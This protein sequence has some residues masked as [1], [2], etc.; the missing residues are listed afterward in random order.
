MEKVHYLALQKNRE[1]DWKNLQAANKQAEALDKAHYQAIKMNSDMIAKN[2]KQTQ[3]LIN[4]AF[5][6]KQSANSASNGVAE[7]KALEVLNRQYDKVLSNLNAAKNSGKQLSDSELSGINRRIEA[8][9]NLGSRQ[10]QVEKDR[11]VLS[12]TQ[13]RA[14]TQVNNLLSGKYKDKVDSE[15]LS[16]LLTRLKNLDV[17]TANFK[18]RAK[19]IT[20]QIN[21]LGSEARNASAQTAGLGDKLKQTFNNMLIYSGV[22]S[23]FY[24]AI[25]AFKS[26]VQHIFD[27]DAAMTDLRKVTDET[28]LTYNRFLVTANET[29]NAIGGVTVDVVKSTTEWARL[30]YTIQ[31]AQSLAKQTLV[32][33]NVGDIKSAEDASK[34]LISTIKGFGIEVDNEGKNI[35]KIVDIYNEVGNKFAISSAGIGEA[36]RRSA[37]SLS[38]AGNSIEQSVALATAA[39]STIQD[40]ARVGQMLK[41]VSMRLRG[42]SDEGEDL[43]DLIPSMEKKFAALGLTLKKMTTPLKVHMTFLKTYPLFGLTYQI[44]NVQIFWSL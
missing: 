16:N 28:T 41:T 37:A 33:Q 31:Q 34:S 38:E 6:G 24:G 9:N 7:A 17:Q 1:M 20:D 15:Q 10:R 32:Y 11:A 8:L 13:L 40:P 25:N 43:T 5:S 12:S 35:T 39:N 26:G 14:E 19:E 3:S 30:G 23:I 22:G 4:S 42:V 2:Q 27:I 36:L 29:A 44:F 18:G 21:K